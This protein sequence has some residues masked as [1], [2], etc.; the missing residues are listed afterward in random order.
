MNTVGNNEMESDRMEEVH[1]ANL[2]PGD[3]VDVKGKKLYI[4]NIYS[5]LAVNHVTPSVIDVFG[6]CVTIEFTDDKSKCNLH[7]TTPEVHCDDISSTMSIFSFGDTLK[8][9]QQ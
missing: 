9:Y 2:K 8:R 1:V 5:S 7:Y 4:K 3:L 6:T